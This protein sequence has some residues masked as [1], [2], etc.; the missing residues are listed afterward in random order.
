MNICDTLACE[1]VTL[2]YARIIILQHRYIITFKMIL[3]EEKRK[4]TLNSLQSSKSAQWVS[5]VALL[6]RSDHSGSFKDVF[7]TLKQQKSENSSR[8][9][10]NRLVDLKRAQADITTSAPHI[11]NMNIHMQ[12]NP[13]K[14][15]LQREGPS[16]DK[17]VFIHK[18]RRGRKNEPPWNGTGQYGSK[19]Y[20]KHLKSQYCQW[21]S[22]N[23]T[24]HNTYPQMNDLIRTITLT[25]LFMMHLLTVLLYL[26]PTLCNFSFFLQQDFHFQ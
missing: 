14:I 11:N 8:Q 3:T 19:S 20:S 22:C 2:R 1:F 25:M 18:D 17:G 15:Q 13:T 10:I 12:L 23:I 4:K 16:C 7:D 9:K 6:H 21:Y 5:G 24:S 26:Y